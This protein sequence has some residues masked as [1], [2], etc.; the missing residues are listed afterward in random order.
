MSYSWTHIY[1]HNEMNDFCVF[2]HF[3]EDTDRVGVSAWNHKAKRFQDF[4]KPF[5]NA[6]RIAAKQLNA[7]RTVIQTEVKS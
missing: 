1:I 5:E 7:G 6:I 2:M 3:Y 4:K